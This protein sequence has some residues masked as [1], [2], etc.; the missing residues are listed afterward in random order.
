MYLLGISFKVVVFFCLFFF[1]LQL[2]NMFPRLFGWIKNRQ[3]VL[4]NVEMN[5][6]DIKNLIKHLKETL[7]PGLCRGLVDC[8]LIRKQKEE[9]R[10]CVVFFVFFKL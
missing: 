2:F 1:L 3:V 9:V 5:V 10:L 7:E 8:F 4:K 6:R